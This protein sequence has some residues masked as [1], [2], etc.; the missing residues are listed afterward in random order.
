MAEVLYGFGDELIH[1]M[2]PTRFGDAIALTVELWNLGLSAREDWGG[3]VFQLTEGLS[4]RDLPKPLEQEDLYR[5][6]ERRRAEFGADRRY[7][8]DYN[9]TATP[10]G[11]SVS[12]RFVVDE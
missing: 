9:I 12:V 3:E 10:S 4:A 1:R 11:P 6:L 5:C 7:V 8:V 2:G